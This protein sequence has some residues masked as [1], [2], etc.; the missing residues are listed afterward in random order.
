[1][2]E[3]ILAGEVAT[4]PVT[5]GPVVGLPAGSTAAARWWRLVDRPA[6]GW[7]LVVGLAGLALALKLFTA[8]KTRGTND[9]VYWELFLATFQESGGIGVYRQLG[10]FNHPPFMLHALQAMDRLATA[11]GLPFAF[12][13][14]VPAV[15]ADLGSLAVVAHLIT[16]VPLRRFTGRPTVS[17][18]LL[19][20]APVSIMVSGFHGNTDPV[21]VFFVLLAV[22]LLAVWQQALLAGAAFGMAINIKVV[23]L[24]FVPTLFLYLPGLFRRLGF[25]AAA[26]A[27]VV[28][29]SLPFLAEDAAT[30][31][32]NVLGYGSF[33]GYWGI[34]R[35]LN[36]VAPA[37]WLNLAYQEKGRLLALG[38]AAIAAV[39]M[40]WPGRKA[41]LFLQ[42]GV[43]ALLFMA[44][45][46]GFGIQY[47]AWLVPW[48]VGAGPG[49]AAVYY[50][51]SGLFAAEV[52][53]YWSGGFPWYF[54]DARE[55]IPE[56]WSPPIVVAELV[57]WVSV[58]VLLALMIRRVV[59]ARRS[60]V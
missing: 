29:G 3:G 13:L 46:P 17:L 7:L 8:L 14:R 2:V 19:A 48:V 56:W 34:P 59:I 6:V 53:T 50:S 52:Y 25:F 39:P 35:V 12:W 44:L 40:N 38:M 24:I 18:A 20:L 45:T 26:A 9:V 21:M 5:T 41:P 36:S 16:T 47:L 57:C 42:C 23:P 31:A 58:L 30:I 11:T 27:V 55:F 33:Y 28:A 4:R 51:T 60:P 54:A 10:W 37:S 32:G 49:A 1:M 43:V 15:A 22:Y